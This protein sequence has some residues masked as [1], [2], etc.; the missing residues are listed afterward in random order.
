MERAVPVGWSP[1]QIVERVGVSSRKVYYEIAA[2]TLKAHRIGGRVVV[3]EPDLLEWLHA[4][5]YAETPRIRG[6]GPKPRKVD[7]PGAP[8]GIVPEVSA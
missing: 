6:R 1:R 3:H 7:R 4:R 2:G 8:R 5:P